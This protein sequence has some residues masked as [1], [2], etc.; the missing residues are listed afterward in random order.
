MW[1][2]SP[3]YFHGF[4]ISSVD[5]VFLAVSPSV[6][7]RSP[8]DSTLQDS[9]QGIHGTLSKGRRNLDTILSKYIQISFPDP[10]IQTAGES[11][12]TQKSHFSLR[13]ET[14]K[15]K[16]MRA[17]HLFCLFIFTFQFLIDVSVW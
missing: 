16:M 7:I 9:Y 4:I 13:R 6:W 12:E 10:R 5:S 1:E 3:L 11:S 15:R 17:F 8:S 2:V 14:F